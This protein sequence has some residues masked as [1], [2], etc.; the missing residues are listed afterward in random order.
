MVRDEEISPPR[1][2]AA[3]DPRVNTRQSLGEHRIR[4]LRSCQ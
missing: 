2:T 4:N 3:C 1:L